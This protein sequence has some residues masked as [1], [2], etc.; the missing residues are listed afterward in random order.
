[1]TL[2]IWSAQAIDRAQSS[3]GAMR[4]IERLYEESR[5]ATPDDLGRPSSG[6]YGRFQWIRSPGRPL[7]DESAYAPTPVR[8][9]VRWTS[10]G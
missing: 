9:F 3:V 4:V 2:L 6:T 1:M 5:L 8:F 10:G 7:G